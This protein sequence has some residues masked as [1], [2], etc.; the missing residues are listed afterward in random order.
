MAITTTLKK[1]GLNDKEIKVYL[2]L[3]K[4]GRT[5]PTTLA[6]LT[7][8]NRATLYNIAN[9]LVS[10]GII[11][12]DL[13]GKVLHFTP[14]PPDSLNK[15]LEDTKR[16]LNEK[17][18]LI[19]KAIDELSLIGAS[20]NYPVPKMQFVEE[21]NLKKFLFDNL[22]KWSNAIL[23]ADG[24]WWG[25]QDHTF[26]ENFSDWIEK[27]WQIKE[28][29]NEKFKA[30]IL[31][32]VSTIEKKIKNRYPKDKRLVRF[33]DDTNFTSSLWIAGNYLIVVSTHAHPF[34][35]FEIHD[36]LLTHNLRE[37]FKRLWATSKE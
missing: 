33:F 24:V 11:A 14:L 32:N 4:N 8:L 20:Q 16:E 7:K 3:L 12:Q 15:I 25:F 34:Y 36:E 9:S 21:K 6:S 35:A 5:K 30:Q 28:S 22:A 13:G 1:L 2:A 27:S 29:K 26:V 23:T 17:E 19:K 18:N 10:K 31:T 37:M